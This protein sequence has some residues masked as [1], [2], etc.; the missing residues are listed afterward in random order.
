MGYTLTFSQTFEKHVKTFSEKQRKQIAN[1]L[2]ILAENPAHPSLRVKK[3]R[4]TDFWEMSVNV[5][6]R[7]IMKFEK[8]TVILLLDIGH[9]RV[10][11]KWG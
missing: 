3:I 7:I 6:V 9:H 10:I 1:K 2:K 5:D 8:N 4:W 11:E